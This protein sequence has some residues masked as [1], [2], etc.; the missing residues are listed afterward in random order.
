M[1]TGQKSQCI[2]N[3]D[4]PGFFFSRE[5]TPKWKEKFPIQ[6][7]ETKSLIMVAKGEIPVLLLPQNSIVQTEQQRL[8]V[9]RGLSN[10]NSTKYEIT[11]SSQKVVAWGK[12]FV[13]A[14]SVKDHLNN[15][16]S[17]A[18]QALAKPL[19][20]NIRNL[21]LNNG[22]K[23]QALIDPS[24]GK[25]YPAGVFRSINVVQESSVLHTDDFLRDGLQKPDFV[26]PEILRGQPY[27]QMAFNVLLDNGGYEPDAL[28][29]YNRFYKKQDEEQCMNEWQFPL[30]LV[31]DHDFVRFVPEV[32]N[33]YFFCTNNYHD[34]RGGSPKA[35]RITFGVFAIYVPDENLIM[36]YN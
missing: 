1:S 29:V 10:L 17:P 30:S 12:P 27:F 8:D 6:K 11:D 25:E 18:V 16:P 3:E 31:E 9:L 24:S 14:P 5:T 32:G 35:H 28:F 36:L 20:Q 34:V 23:V 33:E 13:E 4:E 21:F 15:P 22:F 19:L 7:L 26:I 2:E